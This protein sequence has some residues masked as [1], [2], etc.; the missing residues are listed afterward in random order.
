MIYRFLF[1]VRSRVVRPD[2]DPS[3]IA[4][5]GAIAR[6]SGCGRWSDDRGIP[7]DSARSSVRFVG[8]ITA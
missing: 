6:G 5:A 7:G 4:L 2:A 1:I 3:G 8:P